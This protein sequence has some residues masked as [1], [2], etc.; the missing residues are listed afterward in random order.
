MASSAKYMGVSRKGTFN[1]SL[2]RLSQAFIP[3]IAA[4]AQQIR[5]PR[6]RALGF[7]WIERHFVQKFLD[8]GVARTLSGHDLT[9]PACACAGSA[10][11]SGFSAQLEK[12]FGSQRFL[13]NFEVGI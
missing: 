5:I 11:L 2:A 7:T 1:W 8:S 13:K 3:E 12:A 6:A 4:A 10:W 9:P